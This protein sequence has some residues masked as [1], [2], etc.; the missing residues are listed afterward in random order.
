MINFI[1]KHLI[2][3]SNPA[4]D[5]K[6]Y[7]IVSG[8]VGIFCNI[9][10]FISK[11]FAGILTS[12]VSIMA[13]ALNN[14]SDAGSSIATLM[15]FKL[16]DMP[17]D[18]EHPFGHGRY[19][20]V[21]GFVVSLIIILMGIELF[22]ASFEKIIS[23]QQMIFHMLSFIIMLFSIVLKLWMCFFNKKIGKLIDSQTLQAAA[24]DSLSDVVATSAVI[25]GMLITHFFDVN[26]DGYMGI[27]V[28]L[29]IL[30]TGIT[31][32]KETLNPLLGSAPPS[33]FV[34]E[35]KKEVLSYK[36][37][38]GVHDLIVHSYGA[39]KKLI[40]LHAEVSAYGDILKIHDVIDTIERDIKQK[41][42]CDVVI[43]MD[44]IDTEDK[45][46]K[47]LYHQTKYIVETIDPSLKIHDFRVIKSIGE[48]KLFFDVA[49]PFHYQK[50]DEEMV[51]QIKDK[52]EQLG[53]NYIA[54][55]TIDHIS[56]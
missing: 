31:T 16:A 30:Y 17:P 19:E 46:T 28:A 6:K 26:I 56:M 53:S 4:E 42:L 29:F 9:L 45:Q 25:F 48:I 20:Y 34:K 27:L 18:K 7:G 41:F 11:L 13:D 43:H 14:L 15:G 33:D 35:I 37:I 32:A 38:L 2:K 8:Y 40:S 24:M 47:Q 36:G 39:E 1:I 51:Q 54:T 52:V 5:R 23:P 10:L 12:S 55:I 3:P 22:K 50:T 49:I 21:S 44:P